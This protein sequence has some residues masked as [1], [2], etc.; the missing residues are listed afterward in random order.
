MQ[1]TTAYIFF[2][3]IIILKNLSLS[4][5]SKYPIL[6]GFDNNLNK[7][8]SLQPWKECTKEDKKNMYDNVSELYHM[9]SFFLYFSHSFCGCRL[10]NLFKS[11]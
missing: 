4:P 8:H 11:L 10:L 1:S 2:M 3:K 7:F 5:S 6:P 9:H